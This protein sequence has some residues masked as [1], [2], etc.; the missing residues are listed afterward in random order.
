M[1]DRNGANAC[2]RLTKQQQW[3]LDCVYDGLRN[4]EIAVLIGVSEG[5]V[6]ATVQQLFRKTSTRKRVQ[7]VR[8]A[9]EGSLGTS[10]GRPK[11]SQAADRE[12]GPDDNRQR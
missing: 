3:V 5:A 10:R 8:I 1:S 2:H 4:K 7:L 6:K 12:I 9:L 11:E